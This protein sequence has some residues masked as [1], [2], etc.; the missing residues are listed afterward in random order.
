MKTRKLIMIYLKRDFKKTE[1][2]LY[3]LNIIKILK[4]IF[5]KTIKKYRGKFVLTT[6]KIL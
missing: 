4:N 2:I 3:Y 6:K 5:T 1:K